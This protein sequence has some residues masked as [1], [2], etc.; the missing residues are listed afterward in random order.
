MLIIEETGHL[1]S[2]SYDGIINIWNYPEGKTI[3]K[4]E[5]NE[6]HRCITYIFD[7]KEVEEEEDG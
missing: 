2:C 5:K 4:F 7:E 3:H 1:V 6:S